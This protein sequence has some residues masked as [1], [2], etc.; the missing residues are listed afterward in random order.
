MSHFVIRHRRQQK[1]EHAL[2]FVQA[3][4]SH[5]MCNAYMVFEALHRLKSKADRVLLYPDEWR[6]SMDR[7]DRNN[8]LLAHAAKHYGVKLKPIQLLGLDGEADAGTMKRPSG[9][10]SGITKLRIFE[11]DEYERIIHFDS[12]V[13]V[14]QHLDELFFLPKTPMAMPR[15]YSSEKPRDAWPLSTQLM[16]L[17]PDAA[18]TKTMWETLQSWRLDP[19]REQSQHY[20]TDLLN[21]RFGSSALVL[22]HRPY[23]MQS[24]EFRMHDHKAYMGLYNSPPTAVEWDTFRMMKEAKLIHFND[25]PLPK[26]WVMWP[27]DGLAEIQPNCGGSH[28]GT[29]LERELWKGLYDDF[30]LRR[31]ELCKILSVPA[32][33]WADW[34]NKSG[35]T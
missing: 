18:E 5:A 13:I 26:P 1:T 17:Q 3:T 34:K 29:C 32:P 10:D 21:D 23:L 9:F 22:P 30:R 28:A 12:D 20:D 19:S 31:K 8:Q 27:I 35:A 7:N 16:L 24:S 11:L 6:T 25:W 2:T 14:Q 33:N 15:D 4:D